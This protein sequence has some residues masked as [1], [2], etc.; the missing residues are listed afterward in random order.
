M[1]S[2]VL[3]AVALLF[4]ARAGVIGTLLSALIFAVHLFS[5]VGN[6]HVTSEVARTNLGWMLMIGIAFS[7][8]FAPQKRT[9][10]RH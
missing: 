6:Y 9:F 3:L 8:L 2:I 7:F 5:P 1:F 4:G 10:R